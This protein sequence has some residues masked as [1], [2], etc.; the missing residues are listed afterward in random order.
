[1]Y[2]IV[3]VCMHGASTDLVAKKMRQTIESEK[4]EATVNAYSHTKLPVYIKEADIVLVGPQ[5]AFRVEGY[6]QKYQAYNIPIVPINAT[7]YGMM[8]GKKI[9]SYAINIIEKE[10]GKKD[11]QA[12][13]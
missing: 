5:L 3:L 2:N 10:R 12:T 1:M 11:D 9:L 13:N 7:D 4:I 8:D 6:K